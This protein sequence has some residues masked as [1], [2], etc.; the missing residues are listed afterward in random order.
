ML[1]ELVIISMW[2]RWLYHHTVVPKRTPIKSSDGVRRSVRLKKRMIQLSKRSH[3]ASLCFSAS[4]PNVD[5]LDTEY[6]SV[7]PTILVNSDALPAVV[8]VD[9]DAP[10]SSAVPAAGGVGQ[11]KDVVAGVTNYG[12]T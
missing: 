12:A 1:V 8:I 5:E 3:W 6:G 10:R 2:A 4:Y 11:P 7:D 9:E